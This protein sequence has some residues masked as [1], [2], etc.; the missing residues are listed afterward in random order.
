MKFVEH[1][2][3][4]HKLTVIP[5]HVDDLYVLFN[6]ILVN[7]RVSTK[8][9]R[10]IK[11]EE[12]SS[13]TKKRS[14]IYLTVKTEQTEFY[15]FG[16][17]IRVRGKIVEASDTNVTIGSYHTIKVELFKQITIQK[18]EPW[19][20]YDLNNLENAIVGQST[21]LVIVSLD[22]QSAVFSRVGTHATKVILELDPSIPRKSSDVKQ[23]IEAKNTFF[24]T[25]SEFLV[26]KNSEG[27]ADYII[28]GGPGFTRENYADYVKME[29]P[30][31]FPKIHFIATQSSGRPGIRELVLF[32]L[33]REYIEG[34][35]AGEQANLI[36]SFFDELGKNTGKTAYSVQVFE[37]ANMGAVEVLLVLDNLIRGSVSERN[38][39]IELISIVKSN[40]GKVK[41]ISSMQELSDL[42]E[43]FGG[44]AAI[45]RFPLH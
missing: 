30:S 17:I 32:H 39:I 16:D 31:L 29:H 33:P 22:D 21:G 10:R 40:R 11:R 35:E 8:A 15:G 34:N 6:V 13:D 24:K 41:I 36:Q 20:E 9:S 23:H 2:V 14:K 1:D 7:D 28:I 27:I 3:D 37:A 25:I 26:E 12:G 4:N 38:K 43:N 19:Q 45:L 18:K 42:L 5:E 44:L